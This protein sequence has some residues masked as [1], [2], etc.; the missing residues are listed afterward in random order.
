MAMSIRLRLTSLALGALFATA[1]PATADGPPASDLKPLFEEVKKLVHKH[2]PKAEAT[3]TDGTIY[4]ASNTRKF[5][6]HTALLTGEWQDA[7]EEVGPQ[8]GGI[9]ATI[10]LRPGQYGG[11]AAAPQS[12]DYRYFTLWLDA[13]YSKKLDHHLYIH[14]KYPRDVPKE[15]LEGFKRLTQEFDKHARATRN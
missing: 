6:I 4:F 11:M 7:H 12:F 15:F 2:Y 8:K 13:P 1:G 14:M 3:L 9:H 10:E 5:M